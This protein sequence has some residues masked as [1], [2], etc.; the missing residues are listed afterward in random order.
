[1]SSCHNSDSTVS[2]IYQCDTYTLF[3]DSIV[4]GDYCAK[5]ISPTEIVSSFVSEPDACKGRKFN[6][7]LALNQRDNEMEPGRYHEVN[8]DRLDPNEKYLFGQTTE[9]DSSDNS[10]DSPSDTVTFPEN[11]PWTIRVDMRPILKSF[12]DK[13]FYVTP[14]QD[15][16][17]ADSFTGLWIFGDIPPIN[18]GV[19]GRGNNRVI[20]L[21]DRGDSI[22]ELAITLNPAKNGT[23]AEPK[24]WKTDSLSADYPALHTSAKLIDALYN[25]SIDDIDRAL[26]DTTHTPSVSAV[27]YAVYMSLAY[28]RPDESKRLLRALVNDGQV[29]K[30]HTAGAGC[31]PITSD[32]NAWILAAHEVYRV[33]SDTA[34]LK[35]AFRIA[36]ATFNDDISVLR[37]RST[38]LI[39]GAMDYTPLS[40]DV[41]P[42][43]MDATDVFMTQNLTPNILA[44]NAANSLHSMAHDLGLDVESAKYSA[45]YRDMQESINEYLWIPNRGFYSEY[46]YGS[47]FPLQSQCTDNL[48]QA[49]GM[50]Q[51]IAMPEM[52]QS[53]MTRTP[54]NEFGTPIIYPG[55]NKNANI[56]PYV[57]ALWTI[58]AARTS[59]GTAMSAGLGALYRLA[60]LSC[61]TN[62]IHRLTDGKEASS[63]STGELCNACAISAVNFRALA[64][65]DFTNGGIRFSPMIPEGYNTGI[66]ITN[67]RYHASVLDIH[68]SG[69]GSHIAG[70]TIDDIP[71]EPFIPNDLEGRHDIRI[72]MA[73]NTFHNYVLNITTTA[74]LPPIPQ[75]DWYS[76]RRARIN[77]YQAGQSFLVTINGAIQEEM[78]RSDYSLFNAHQFT[79][80]DF[81]PV[82]DN[83]FIGYAGRPYEYI[84]TSALTVL[85]TNKFGH[86]GSYLIKTDS[87]SNE[88]V[89]LSPSHNLNYTINVSASV[90]G[91]YFMDLLYA[92][93]AGSITLQDK[94]AIRSLIVNSEQAG[95]FIFPQ[96]GGDDWRDTG[97]SNR[98]AVHLNKGH[99]RIE[100]KYSMPTDRNAYGNINT[101]LIKKIRFIKK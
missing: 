15:T 65:M 14:T 94:C 72:S 27:S 85:P 41:Y 45:I 82:R 13:G 56:V 49:L 84:P 33:T 63:S 8:V 67:F 36:E 70:F 87:L 55:I 48:G 43:W 17:Y 20:K 69:T 75:V 61:S 90:E 81:V 99:N 18:T 68:I 66:G 101:A 73:N 10:T 6:F 38:G 59:N 22:Y 58:A 24:R 31:W 91:V 74:Q 7:R 76:P 86:T 37:N 11:L 79:V 34:W 93:G 78:S 1:M 21:Y 71:S 23:M 35:E 16:I 47:A 32:R 62:A 95:A 4:Q 5:A 26:D 64:G 52:G 89:E 92:N 2:A 29:T 42:E 46:L 60:A 30:M 80:V 19:H 57:Q 88:F 98:V 25:M 83:R 9:Y 40:A 28:L 100:L 50:I 51:G 77:N 96:R 97:Y 39:Q 3:P 54:V 44:A 53:I 12:H